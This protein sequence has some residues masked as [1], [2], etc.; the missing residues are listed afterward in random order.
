MVCN[1]NV[2]RVDGDDKA[3][4]ATHLIDIG[5][6]GHGGS[7]AINLSRIY[8]IYYLGVL[9]N[10]C[11]SSRVVVFLRSELHQRTDDGRTTTT[12]LSHIAKSFQISTMVVRPQY[13]SEMDT[14]LF[15]Y[16]RNN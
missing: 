13:A 4:A 7:S 9:S 11:Y 6:H 5:G 2:L 10:M 3:A 1:G 14:F 8:G 15:E 12:P 16:E